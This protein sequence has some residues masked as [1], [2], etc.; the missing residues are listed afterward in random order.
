MEHLDP[1]ERSIAF[2][3]LSNAICSAVQETT[4]G[5]SIKAFVAGVATAV[6]ETRDNEAETAALAHG[7]ATRGEEIA[8]AIL[9]N[10]GPLV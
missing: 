5:A 4:V 8:A 3:H 6:A 7:L 9:A 10:T 1:F 2:G